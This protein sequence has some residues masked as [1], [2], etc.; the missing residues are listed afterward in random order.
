MTRRRLAEVGLGVYLTLVAAV[1]WMVREDHWLG[2]LA[3]Y[4]PPLVYVVPLAVVLVAI[5]LTR[6]PMPRLLAC[7]GL[8]AWT[9]LAGFPWRLPAPEPPQARH[10][11]RVMTW[12]IHS[13]RAGLEG[14]AGFLR[15][16]NCDLI[17]LQEA[18]EGKP[19]PV[20]TLAGDLPGYTWARAGE[21]AV[22]SRHPILRQAS[23]DGL[24]GPRPGLD[25]EV[26]VTGRTLRVLDVHFVTAD[27][28]QTLARARN[29]RQYVV[30]A[31]EVRAE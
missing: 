7:A 6:T 15:R 16:S 20:R 29:K 9:C 18:R 10:R 2:V 30:R 4:A 31:A 25:V 5:R 13:G 12:N 22:L 17:L 19:D 1:A 27:P 21:V 8:I 11:I 24:C 14:I 28:G 26:Q 23:L 3:R